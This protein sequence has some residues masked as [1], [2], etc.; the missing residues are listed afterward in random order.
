[1]VGRI[2]EL[3]VEFVSGKCIRFGF[4][5]TLGALRTRLGEYDALFS[6]EEP[7]PGLFVFRGCLTPLGVPEDK[8]FRITTLS[9]DLPYD[10][11]GRVLAMGP[12]FGEGVHPV[13]DLPERL[14]TRDFFACFH[15]DAPEEGL[16]LT[17]KLPAK[18]R[19]DITLE[20]GAECLRVTASTEVP[21][22][23]EG[24][25]QCQ[26]WYLYT[27][28]NP[29]RAL[30]DAAERWGTREPFAQPIGWSTWDYYFTS[31]TE[32]DVKENVDLIAADPVLSQKVRYI[33]L[34]D[35]WQQREGDWRSGI[36]YPSGL[37]ALVE[38]IRDKG[39]EAGIW[40]A[41]TRLH[42]LCGTV[43]RRHGFLVRDDCG[44]PI[45]D[46]DMYVLD[47][48]H[49]DGE[50]FLRET[51][52]YL[53]QCGF[54]FYKLDFISNML[55]CAQR[56]YDKQ[57]GPFDALRRLFTIVRET[58]PKGSH[59]MG[60]S[61]PYGTGPGVA[62]SRRTGWDIHNVWGHVE[63]C[64]G[65][66]LPQFAANGRIYRSDLDYL[67]VRGP[68]TSGDPQTNVLDPKAGFNRA[69]PKPFAWRA[70]EDFSCREA[71]TWCAAMLMAG[72]SIFLGDALPKLNGRGLELV[73]KTLEAADFTAAVPVLDGERIPAVW[74]K[75]E[76]GK[77]YVFNFSG[78]TRTF[79]PEPDSLGSWRDIFT[80]DCYAPLDGRLLITLEAHD[81]VCLEAI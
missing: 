48:T 14:Q 59:I 76:L 60:C 42:N 51:F 72:S 77:L 54:T 43:M 55:S 33:A 21:F 27:N 2:L 16:T 81:C 78:E 17:A 49:P 46:E 28:R 5:H 52:S 71:K 12:S 25:V 19:S 37:K 80:G 57:A 30:E 18:F 65:A 24:E 8:V 63:A 66:Y 68:E 3:C 41:P 79:R 7:E 47:P 20:R 44:D 26:E 9:L 1:M 10:G 56:F 15:P 22:S 4:D 62:D 73:K 34:D 39:F 61:L 6:V 75:R 11:A 23:F 50:A 29:V 40:I 58:V 13:T 45:T 32:S 53:A 74:H 35:G 36:R 31:A 70:G 69:N 64:L 38:Y 67:V